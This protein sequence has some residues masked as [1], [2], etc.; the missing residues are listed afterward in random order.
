MKGTV[1]WYNVKNGYG[2]IVGEDGG[3][4][5]VHH[6]QIP[7]GAK[8]FEEDTVNFEPTENERGKQAQNIVKEGGSSAPRKVPVKKETKKEDPAKEVVLDDDLEDE[9]LKLD[10]PEDDF[11]DD[12]D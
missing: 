1:K 6:T 3:D 4:Y 8:L 5:F 9:N 2:F 11:D 10:L 12:L 7:G